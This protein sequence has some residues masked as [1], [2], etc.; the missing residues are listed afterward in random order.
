MLLSKANYVA[1]KAFPG[2]WIHDLGV[3]ITMPIYTQVTELNTIT[4]YSPLG[5]NCVPDIENKHSFCKAVPAM[6]FDK[7][8]QRLH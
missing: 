2:T 3:A 5:Y 8:H 7:W 1:F 6:T 4:D